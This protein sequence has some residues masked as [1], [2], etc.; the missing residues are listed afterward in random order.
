MLQA[1]GFLVDLV[2]VEPHRLGEVELQQPV[3]TDHLQRNPS[4]GVGQPHAVVAVVLDQAKLGQP[5]DHI[6]DGRP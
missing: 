2:P 1:L 4:A 6:G 5:L 3:V